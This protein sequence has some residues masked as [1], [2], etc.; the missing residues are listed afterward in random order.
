MSSSRCSVRS[1][2]RRPRGGQARSPELSLASLPA[3]RSEGHP[4]P[5]QLRA[6][7]PSAK[8]C[9]PL[10]VHSTYFELYRMRTDRHWLHQKLVS[11]AR[12]HGLKAAAREFGCSRNTVRKWLRR[13][14]PGK[15]SSLAEHSRRPHH[16]PHQISCGLE[17]Q[18]VKLRQ[19]TGFGAERLQHEFAL[20]CS[21]NAIARVLR[22]HQLARSRKKKH[23]TKK[24]LRSV[25]RCWKLFAQLSTDT[26]YLQDIPQYWLPMTRLKLPRFQYTAREPVSGACFTGYADELSKSYATFLAEQLSVHLAGHG[27][28]LAGLVWQTDN[29]SEFLENKQ[30]QG[31]PSTVRALGSDHRY[32]PPKR[33]TWQSD[34]ETVHRLVED[35]FFDRKSLRW[36]AGLLG[37]GH[38]LLALL[39]SGASQPRQGMAEQIL[40]AMAPALAGALFHWR[41][42]NL[43]QR[44]HLY[45][46]P[47]HH[48]GHDLPSFPLI[49]HFF[50]CPQSRPESSHILIKFG[51]WN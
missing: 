14:Q 23:H 8:T 1:E 10:R 5:P 39:Q 27:V 9:D 30:E 2:D 13:Y 4:G 45:L 26:K 29:G 40:K 35:E 37:Q 50:A 41:P 42:L 16:C 43:T 3:E 11:F 6:E 47:P 25:K 19:R 7:G 33:Y 31:L 20:S 15:P 34:V 51:K 48:R 17:G 44:H 28:D 22:Q 38:H 46:P 49:V 21:H 24:Q 36:P 12:T 18:I 32:I